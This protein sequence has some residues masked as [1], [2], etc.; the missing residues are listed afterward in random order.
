MM[1]P[2]REQRV[3]MTSHEVNYSRFY[4][5]PSQGGFIISQQKTGQK[6]YLGCIE[7]TRKIF[8][9]SYIYSVLYSIN[10][11]IG[12]Q[13][14]A[15]RPILWGKEIILSKKEN[16]LTLKLFSLY[17]SAYVTYVVRLTINIA[18]HV[19]CVNVIQQEGKNLFCVC[20]FARSVLT[21]Y[22]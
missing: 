4:F 22:Y 16:I 8:L 2:K 14:F 9:L 11:E 12:L 17:R 1:E 13:F 5:Y 15:K 18:R 3:R 6:A 21:L 19:I 7:S 20:F 10:M